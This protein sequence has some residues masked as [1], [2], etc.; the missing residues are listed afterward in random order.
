MREER[1]AIRLGANDL[2][3][4]IDAQRKALAGIH[5]YCRVR[6]GEA[7]APLVDALAQDARDAGERIIR[8]S[9][10]LA[11]IQAATGAGLREMMQSREAVAA[12][13]GNVEGHRTL[14]PVALSTEV[15]QEVLAAIGQLDGKGAALPLRAITSVSLR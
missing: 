4:R 8:A 2:A 10:A 11:A 5:A 1:E 12:I 6:A 15:P 14:L 3:S 9:G 7:A 13:A